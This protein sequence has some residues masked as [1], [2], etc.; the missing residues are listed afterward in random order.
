MASS[1]SIVLSK[2]TSTTPAWLA[3]LHD[4]LEGGRV[5]RVDDDRV[6]AGI[7]EVV[8]RRDLRRDIL[9]GRDDL[10]LLQHLLDVRLIGIGLGGLDHLDAPGIADEAVGQRDPVGAGLLGVL[11]ELG[12]RRP[13]HV[14]LRIIARASDRLRSRGL[15]GCRGRQQRRAHESGKSHKFHSR[16]PFLSFPAEQLCRSSRSFVVFGGDTMVRCLLAA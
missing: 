6:I 9:A 5:L 3:R 1:V 11:E 14:A 7:D 16:S 12:L 13:R 10:E 8:D 2:A 4:R 15:R